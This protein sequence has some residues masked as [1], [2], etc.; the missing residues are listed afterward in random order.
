MNISTPPKKHGRSEVDH[1]V[2]TL[3]ARI[4]DQWD[5]CF[6]ADVTSCSSLSPLLWMV[7]YSFF[8]GAGGGGC[9]G[10]GGNLW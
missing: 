9:G 4:K 7:V 2:N 10:G 1:S 6:G 5:G 8:C 3:N